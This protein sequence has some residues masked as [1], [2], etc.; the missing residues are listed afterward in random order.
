[1]TLPVLFVLDDDVG[2]VHAL[3]DDLSRRFGEDF[4]VI[5]DSS[6]AAGLATLRE[7]ADRHQAVALLIVDHDMSEMP[8]V[9]FLA[10]AHA[11]HPLAKRVLLVE[12]DYSVRSPVVQAMTL[13][14]ADYHF[15]KPWMLEQDLY[16]VVSEFLADWAKDQESRLRPVPRRRAG[17]RTAARTSC[18]TCSPASTCRSTSM[19]PT[20]STAA[21]CSRSGGLDA[22]R[23]PVMIRHDNYTM[24]E[25]DAGSDHRRRSAGAS[26]ATSTSATSSSSEQG[27]PVSPPPSTPHPKASRRSCWKRPCPAARRGA[28]R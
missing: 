13:G 3:R 15:T 11:V 22:S 26:A 7:L 9:D 23:L 2:V 25:P 18:V 1:M 21:G 19:R 16:R 17:S 12:R 20:A 27:R 10:R 28:A 14:E 8:G 24:V 4:N 6:A 5:G